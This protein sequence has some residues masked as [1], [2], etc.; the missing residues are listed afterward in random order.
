MGHGKRVKVGTFPFFSESFYPWGGYGGVTA[1]L[2]S[3][4]PLVW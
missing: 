1:L 4:P 2:Y 3:G